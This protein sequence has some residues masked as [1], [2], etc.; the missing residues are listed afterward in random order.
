VVI[1]CIQSLATSFR[2]AF[3]AYESYMAPWFDVGRIKQAAGK[4]ANEERRKDGKART[5]S[6]QVECTQKLA[7]EQLNA[8]ETDKKM[9]R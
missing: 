7:R 5:K 3:A 1:S 8:F 4:P 6:A 9:F 2:T